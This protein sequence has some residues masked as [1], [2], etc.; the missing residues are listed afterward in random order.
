[1][2]CVLLFYSVLIFEHLSLSEGLCEGKVDIA[3]RCF[4]N[5]FCM[6][7]E[8]GVAGFATAVQNICLQK[9]E[10]GLLKM[11]TTTFRISQVIR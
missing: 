9:R 11:P 8:W 1:M 6:Q 3:K 10:N 7:N 2:P 4:V 5:V